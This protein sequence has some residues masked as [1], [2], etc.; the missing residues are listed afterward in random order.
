[1]IGS[2]AR[3][4][5]AASAIV[6]LIRTVAAQPPQPCEFEGFDT[7]VRLA[8]IRPGEPMLI[9]HTGGEW[10][11]GYVSR[12]NGAG[13]EWVRSAKLRP[14]EAL[15]NPPL[16]AWLGVWRDGLNRITIRRG[17]ESGQLHLNGEAIWHGIGKVV[18]T[19]EFSGEA[20]PAGN[21]LQIVD[22]GPESCTVD[23]KLIGK[24]LVVDDNSNCGGMNVRFWGIWHRGTKK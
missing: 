6:M 7:S 21:H 3:I 1:M 22:G 23:L 13:P 16:G 11:C 14:V 18:H 24:Y 20:V 8:E 17:G 4:F 19:G 9:Y 10:T 5:A 15:E 12:S 2:A